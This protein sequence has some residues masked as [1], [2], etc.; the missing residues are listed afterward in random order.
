MPTVVGIMMNVSASSL[1]EVD[2]EFEWPPCVGGQR[3]I[4]QPTG[5]SYRTWISNGTSSEDQPPEAPAF[6]EEQCMACRETRFVPEHTPTLLD[7]QD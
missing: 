1:E 4:W 6:R 5:T 2:L 3:H 7:E